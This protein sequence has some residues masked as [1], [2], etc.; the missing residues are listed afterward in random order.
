MGKLLHTLIGICCL[1]CT[2]FCSVQVAS[3]QNAYRQLT[4]LD[5]RNDLVTQSLMQHIKQVQPG[6][7]G[8]FSFPDESTILL[9]DYPPSQAGSLNQYCVQ[10]IQSSGQ[11]PAECTYTP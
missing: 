11:L 5:I 8:L 10:A 2:I 6:M 1:L 3:A 4:G 7:M 9:P